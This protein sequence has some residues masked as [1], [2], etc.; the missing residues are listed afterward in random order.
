MDVSYLIRYLFLE[1]PS[2]RRK[3]LPLLES[4]SRM[5]E[6]LDQYKRTYKP[7]YRIKF[8]ETSAGSL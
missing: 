4:K 2:Q 1:M 6:V 7:R 5:E 3:I 8:E